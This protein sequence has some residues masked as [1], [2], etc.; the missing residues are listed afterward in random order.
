M[1]PTLVDKPPEGDDWIHEIKYDGYRTQVVVAGKRAAAYTRHGYDWTSKY[2]RIVEAA[3]QIGRDC[4]LEGELIVQDTAGRPDFNALR[5]DIESGAGGRLVLYA[6]DLLALDGQ[7]LRTE[8]CSE[9]RA[10]LSD[11]LGDSP[12]ARPIQFSQAHEGSGAEFF[13]AVEKMDLEGIVSK[14][15]GSRY[16]S[17]YTRDWLK[18]KAFAEREYLVLGYDAKPGGVRSLLLAEEQHNQLRY[19]GRAM[20][21]I[22]GPKREAIWQR[23]ERHRTLSPAI[24]ELEGKATEWF[25]PVVS[26]RVRHLRGEEMLRHATLLGLA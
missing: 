23:L 1:M 4:H 21:T 19:V 7:D 14:K 11:L 9:R 22:R 24:S 26:V 3:R 16:R 15:G 13:S 2:Q 10:T 12:A 6:F 25:E 17:G 20:V 8:R 18:T 5:S